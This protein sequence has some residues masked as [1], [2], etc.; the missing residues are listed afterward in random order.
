VAL[1]RVADAIG[2]EVGTGVGESVFV[3]VNVRVGEGVIVG[4]RLGVRVTVG[5]RVGVRL[6]T[7]LAVGTAVTL[8]TTEV[9]LL[10]G[11]VAANGVTTDDGRQAAIEIRARNTVI[12]FDIIRNR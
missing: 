12:H 1:A 5:G 4:V 7:G 10:A 2:V 11:S 9:V 8:C 6:A 3:G